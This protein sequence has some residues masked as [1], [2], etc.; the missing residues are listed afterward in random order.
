MKKVLYFFLM[1]VLLSG[2]G[3]S[4]VKEE[5][6]PRGSEQ[7]LPAKKTEANDLVD[8]SPQTGSM[9]EGFT[10][11]CVYKNKKLA[12]AYALFIAEYKKKNDPNEKYFLKE[13]PQSN[14]KATMEQVETEYR[15]EGK[16]KISILL[17][18]PGGST[19]VVM[20]EVGN[21]TKVTTTQSPD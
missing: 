5:K 14:E 10:T 19:G 17:N 21:D 18:F 4:S 2:C 9:E 15:W 11:D 7:V 3:N 13:L 1:V 8:C 12:Q 16:N 20:E 6:S